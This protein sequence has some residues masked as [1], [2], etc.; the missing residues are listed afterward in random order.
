[1]LGMTDWCNRVPYSITTQRVGTLRSDIET[2]YSELR[3]HLQLERAMVTE[4]S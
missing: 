1:M 4:E 3:D 2:H